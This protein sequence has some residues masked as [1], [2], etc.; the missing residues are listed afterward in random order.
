[1][2]SRKVTFE[3]LVDGASLGVNGQDDK[4]LTLISRFFRAIGRLFKPSPCSFNRLPDYGEIERMLSDVYAGKPFIRVPKGVSYADAHAVVTRA[5]RAMKDGSV[6]GDPRAAITRIEEAATCEL[7]GELFDRS[8]A[9]VILLDLKSE[10][11]EDFL[12]FTDGPYSKV[13]F[14]MSVASERVKEEVR[15]SQP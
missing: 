15:G 10:P 11:D 9:V 2:G 12:I 13:L 5:I 14:M 1:M 3:Q 6:V 4:Q 8:R 7:V